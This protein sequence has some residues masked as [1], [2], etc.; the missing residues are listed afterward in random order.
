MGESGPPGAYV[1]ASQ[2]TDGTYA[3]YSHDYTMNANLTKVNGNTTTS[4]G[5][6]WNYVRLDLSMP[7]DSEDGGTF[8]TTHTTSGYCPG[9]N[10]YHTLGGAGTSSIFGVSYSVYHKVLQISPSRATYQ[11]IQPCDVV[12]PYS[13]GTGL[14]R[15][16]GVFPEYL[17]F[18]VPWVD[19]GSTIGIIC[20]HAITAY[21]EQ[22]APMSCDER[23]R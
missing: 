19:F 9:S 3:S 1:Q 21:H 16:S 23:G 18:G 10:S 4:Y 12:C 20:E 6:G 8:Y 22:D 11:L 7:F 5:S 13:W 14:Y 2:I 17:R 15:V